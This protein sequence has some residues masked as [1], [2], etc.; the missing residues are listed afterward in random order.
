MCRNIKPLFNYDPPVTDEEIHACALQ[1]VRKVSGFR[2]PSKI[3]EK[4]FELAVINIS[5]ITKELIDSLQTDSPPRNRDVE[6]KRAKAKA[7]IRFRTE[8]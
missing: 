6:I 8:N 3:N 7:E 1:F 2:Q 4:S 5:K